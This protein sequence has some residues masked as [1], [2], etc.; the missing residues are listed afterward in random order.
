M[1]GTRRSFR[2]SNLKAQLAES[3]CQLLQLLFVLICN[4]EEDAAV[5]RHV[6]AC[7]RNRLVECSC[8]VIVNSHD[9]ACRFHLRSEGNIDILH[10]GKGKYGSFDGNIRFG[11]HKTGEVAHLLQRVPHGCTRRQIDHLHIR[12]LAQKRNGATRTRI[13]LDDIDLIVDHDVLDVEQ[14]LDMKIQCQSLRIVDDGV[15][16]TCGKRLRRIN[17]DTVTR[18]DAGALDMLHDARDD[19]RHAVA[20]TVNFDFRALHIA[21]DEHGMIG[22]DLDRTVQVVAQLLFLV[23]DLHRPAAE[24]IGRSHHDGIADGSGAFDSRFHIGDADSLG[25]RNVRL[26]QHFFEALSILRTIDVVYGSS[27]DMHARLLERCSEIDGRLPAELH[28]DAFR[29]LLVDD[30]QNVFCSQRFKIQAIR[31][32]KVRTD[33]LRIVVDDDG[34]IAH[35]AQR[36]DGMHRAVVEFD[37]LSDADGA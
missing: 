1:Y 27:K 3:L 33:R 18:M 29:L 16:N 37:A 26:A 23:D 34:F 11:R 31:D 4:S 8:V 19:N 13:D 14:S 15:K 36:P 2:R 7:A 24:D 30:V 25:A 17:G 28:D 12:N 32:V 35:L 6:H 22:R 20:Y 10:F 5:L 21:I 9:L